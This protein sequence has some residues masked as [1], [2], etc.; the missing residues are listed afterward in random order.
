MPPNHGNWAVL[1]VF[2]MMVKWMLYKSANVYQTVWQCQKLW[3]QVIY[4]RSTNRILNHTVWFILWTSTCNSIH[5]MIKWKCVSDACTCQQQDILHESVPLQ[6]SP[7]KYALVCTKGLTITGSQIVSPTLTHT[8]FETH[9]C[10]EAAQLQIV[11]WVGCIGQVRWPVEHNM[12]E[13]VVRQCMSDAYMTDMA[14][15]ACKTCHNFHTV[16][17]MGSHDGAQ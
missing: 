13:D 7:R 12:R 14:S 8:Y 5:K 2:W 3:H 6:R 16:S 17:K 15:N 10:D 11:F 4:P 1:L 9:L